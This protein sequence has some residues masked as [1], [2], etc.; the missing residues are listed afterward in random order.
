MG[1]GIFEKKDCKGKFLF[2]EDLSNQEINQKTGTLSPGWVVGDT[3]RS[4][5]CVFKLRG[6]NE[7][8]HSN[9]RIWACSTWRL[10][11]LNLEMAELFWAQSESCGF[12]N[13]PTVFLSSAPRL[14]KI[15][16]AVARGTRQ[17]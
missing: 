7:T 2:L 12:K 13:M 16:P 11:T 1:S 15:S 3:D 14:L 4:L 8:S 9:V 5:L 17:S 10:Y 6:R